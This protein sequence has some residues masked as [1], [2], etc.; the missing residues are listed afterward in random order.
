MSIKKLIIVVFLVIGFCGNVLV[1]MVSFV[2]FNNF[3]IIFVVKLVLVK[4]VKVFFEWYVC[5][6]VDVEDEYI[7]L[8]SLS[9]VGVYVEFDG[10]FV[11]FL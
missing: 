9:V 4:N 2:V 7:L 1:V 8:N 11:C 3:E 5:I 10:I 6:I